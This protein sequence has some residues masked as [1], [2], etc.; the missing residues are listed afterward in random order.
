MSFRF[1]NMA[2]FQLLWILPS[3]FLLW[4]WIVLKQN[5]KWKKTFKKSNLDLLVD[6]VSKERSNWKFLLQLLVTALM[7]IALARPQSGMTK[8]KMKSEGIEIMLVVDVSQSMLAEDVRPSRLELVKKE[9]TRFLSLAGGHKIGLVA[10]AGSSTLLSPLTTDKGAL[11]MFIDSLQ[12]NMVSTQGTDFKRALSEAKGA[13]ERGGN[14]EDEDLA[15]T[16]A[17][18]LIS[19]GED[20]EGGTQD[21]IKKLADQGI[22]LFGVAVGT[23]RGDVIP[24][25]DQRGSLVGTLRDLQGQEVITKVKDQTLQELAQAGKGQFYHLTFGGDSMN[26]LVADLDQIEKASFNESEVTNYQEDFQTL[27]VVALIV[28]LFEML[29]GTRRKMGRIWKGRFEVAQR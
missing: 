22:R 2:A 9:L 29:I 8:Q 20:N 25:R 26:R 12:T 21:V 23:E 3:I 28:A 18:V 13:F 1:E 7:I 16:R 15:V 17:I 6:S 11:S 27:L 4:R 19:D 24:M 10:F 14:G 5:K